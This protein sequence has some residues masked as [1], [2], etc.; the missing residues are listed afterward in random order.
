MQEKKE[1]FTSLNGLRGICIIIIV[2]YHAGGFFGNTFSEFLAPIYKFGGYFGNYIFFMISGFL[3]SNGYKNKIM[4]GTV[5]LSSFIS[6][7]LR[8]IYPLYLI[9]ILA[10]TVI[11]I[12]LYKTTA[13]VNFKTLLLNLLLITSGWVDDIYP[14]N[15]P[16]WFLSMLI[17]CY[18][19]YFFITYISRKSNPVYMYIIIVFIGY[20][21]ENANLRLPF[22][23]N[24]DGEGFMN[25]FIGCLLFEFY[26]LCSKKASKV[27]CTGGI[28]LTILLIF[29]AYKSNLVSVM[30][31]VRIGFSMLICPVIIL[32]VIQFDTLQKVFNLYPFRF[33]GAISMS[34]YLWHMIILSFFNIIPFISDLNNGLKFIIYIILL[35]TLSKLSLEL[36]EKRLIPRMNSCINSFISDKAVCDK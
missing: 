15:L 30:G 6:H 28:A 25:F 35:I 34:V 20:I 24:H 27:I 14:Y 5:K 10:Q 9:T 11:N 13:L 18:I 3:I 17:L 2:L 21:L 23:Y 1:Y 31:D 22:L 8:I 26:K 33:L 12:I 32:T 36:L 16:C 29:L 19:L 4:N 7:R